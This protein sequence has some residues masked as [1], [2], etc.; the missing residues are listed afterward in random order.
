[1]VVRRYVICTA[2][3]KHC[4]LVR[5]GQ[6]VRRRHGV[7]L[8]SYRDFGVLQELDDWSTCRSKKLIFGFLL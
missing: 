7:F 4:V 1:M 5:D 2:V 6:I 8:D 3:L